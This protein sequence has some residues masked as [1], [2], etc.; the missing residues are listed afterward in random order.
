MLQ[1]RKATIDDLAEI[2]EICAGARQFQREQGFMQWADGYPS[3]AV[4]EAD[5]TASKGYMILL[6]NE[7]IGYC[8]IDTSGDAEYDRLH[9]I[10]QSHGRYAAVHRLALGKSARSKGLGSKIFE[11]IE[12]YVANQGINIFKVDTGVENVRMQRIL[13][14]AGYRNCNTHTFI[15]G[16]RIAYEKIKPL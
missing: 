6:N 2:V 12:K 1:L 7:V 3:A 14:R 5:I 9:H 8:V 15:W 4:I 11:E 16:V 13:E 10:W